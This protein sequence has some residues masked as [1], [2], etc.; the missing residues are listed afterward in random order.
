M[1][2]FFTY[3]LENPQGKFYI[4]QTSDL[5]KRL[6]DHNQTDT[7]QGKYTRKNGPWQLVWSEEH[8]TRSSAIKREREI[9][10]WKSAVIIRQ[11]LL[12]G[13]NNWQSPELVRD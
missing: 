1:P 4:G 8:L 5:E 12:P 6:A 11:R 7:K 13:S 2:V 3:I 10:G 9:K